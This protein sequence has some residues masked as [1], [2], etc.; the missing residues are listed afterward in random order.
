MPDHIHMLFILGERLALG[1]CVARLKSKAKSTL[2]FSDEAAMPDW[3]RDFF[4]RHIRPDDDRRS[5]FLSIFLKAYRA[6][7]CART[8]RW[9]W[10]FCRGSDGEWFGPLLD[11]DRP[12]PE[13]MED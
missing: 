2:A 9:P 7:L 6:G 3:E 11:E 8:T 10:Y 4:D 13:W 12:V 5:L 1:K